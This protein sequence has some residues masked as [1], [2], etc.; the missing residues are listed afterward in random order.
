M[1]TAKGLG[2]AQ[3]VRYQCMSPGNPKHHAP[4]LLCR[5]LHDLLALKRP[6]RK[7]G[8]GGNWVGCKMACFGWNT[9]PSA[10]G[11]S[12]LTPLSP[13]DSPRDPLRGVSS[14]EGPG[15]LTWK[16]TCKG[17][18]RRCV[19]WGLGTLMAHFVRLRPPPCALWLHTVAGGGGMGQSRRHQRAQGVSRHLGA[20]QVGG[21]TGDFTTLIC[22]IELQTISRWLVKHFF[23]PLR[24]HNNP[25]KILDAIVSP[26]DSFTNVPCERQPRLT[27]QQVLKI[28]IL[29]GAF[30][31]HTCHSDYI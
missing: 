17:R 22:T 6:S 5:F 15:G 4:R 29:K 21:S 14:C 31:S 18:K 2:A 26:S 3:K 27:F 16:N 11:S 20:L 9:H 30:Q 25:S 7:R 24:R 23:S 19:R 12:T 28:T 10:Q 13:Q 8:P 1:L